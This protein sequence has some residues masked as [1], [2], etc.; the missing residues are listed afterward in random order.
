MPRS[1]FIIK[2]IRFVHTHGVFSSP[3]VYFTFQLFFLCCSSVR[4]FKLPKC[5]LLLGKL[6]YACK[7]HTQRWLKQR[8]PLTHTHTQAYIWILSGASSSTCIWLSLH[9][10]DVLGYVFRFEPSKYVFTY[11]IHSVCVCMRV[12]WTPFV[13]ASVFSFVFYT[14][15]MQTLKAAPAKKSSS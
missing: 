8:Y 14:K 9:A 7:I 11:S 10:S 2:K 4:C 13:L 5:R 1:I 15:M 12:N 3:L 6:N